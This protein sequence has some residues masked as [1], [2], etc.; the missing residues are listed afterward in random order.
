[1]NLFKMTKALFA[2]AP[3]V[4]P[5]ECAD[6]V[7]SGSAILIDV[8]EPSEWTEGVVQHAVM[9]SL[10]DLTGSRAHWAEFLAAH[11]DRELLVYCRSGGRSAIATRILAA[12]GFPAAN[13]GSLSAWAGA[14]WPIVTPATDGR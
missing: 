5:L 8:R 4:E 6:R 3:R 14:G 9:L 13:A 11:K 1:M 10:T 2:S 12:E 7:R